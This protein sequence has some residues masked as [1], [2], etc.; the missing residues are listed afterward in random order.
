MTHRKAGAI[1]LA[2]L[3]SFPPMS[4]PTIK[5]GFISRSASRADA[6]RTESGGMAAKE[7]PYS[8]VLGDIDARMCL[9]HSRVSV[10]G[11]M[12]PMKLIPTGGRFTKALAAI[13][14]ATIALMAILLL[15]QMRVHE[16][17][18]AQEETVSLSRIIS[19]QTSRS[20]QA[21][22]LAL[23]T[24]VDR[25]AQAERLGVNFDELPI[26]TMLRSRVEG[27]PQLRSLF[28]TDSDGK[29]LSSA[30]S[31][32][33]PN[34]T[35][36][37]R[38][39]FLAPKS[40]RNGERY[41]GT[42]AINRVDGKR[43]LFFSRDFRSVKGEF[44]GVVVASL[45]IEYLESLYDSIKLD[46]VGPIVLYLEDGTV[47]A[48]APRDHMFAMDS[49]AGP[50][51]NKG[52]KVAPEIKTVRT[53]GENSGVITYRKVAGFPLVLGVD[54]WR[55]TAWVIAVAAVVN[56]MLLLA[57][58][59]LLLRRQGRE[60][61]L[62][63]AALESGERLRA[64]VNSAM[65]AIITVDSDRRV[66]V[67]NPAAERMFGYQEEDVRGMLI[68]YLLSEHS[69][70]AYWDDVAEY[71]DAGVVGHLG[72]SRREIVGLRA[73][74]SE[75]PIESAIAQV[76]VNGSPMFTAILRDIDERR[77]AEGELR[78]SHQQLRELASSLQAVREEERT[79]IARELHDELGQQLLR[80]R[81]DLSWL[82]GRMKDMAPQLLA[83]VAE[84]K[85]FTEGT[86]DA[87]RRVTTQLRPPLLDDLGLADAAR[88]QLN[89][90]AQRTGLDV[91][92][93]IAIDD[94][95]LDQR[96]AI[97]VFRILQES[98][99]NV[100]RHS[101][102]TSVRV[103]LSLTPDGL[104][105]EVVDNGHGREGGAESNLGHG[106][107]GIRERTLM[108]GG[109]TE[110]YSTPSNGFTV[111]VRVPLVVPDSVGVQ[112]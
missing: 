8:S 42:P 12:R 33:A 106:L 72:D 32:P 4:F 74:G 16:L 98:L 109:R 53:V 14:V 30:L 59:A 54:D 69:R 29:I 77:K 52:G 66:V 20:L 37:D 49:P 47:V 111:R 40:R 5:A 92:S 107:I 13:A 103:S 24:T 57:A 7:Y 67:F 112:K 19:E 78:N 73:D 22:D 95:E 84:M 94:L 80:M 105:L 99:T 35:V 34:I 21:V 9:G 75:F 91:I 3:M 96:I 83:K 51:M 36:K 1:R 23:E 11:T 58:T 85:R 82:A 93:T 2:D 64:V 90:F 48:R 15:W 41:V 76:V 86:V 44:A 45:D 17:Q 27:M 25:L 89:E 100:A 110:I 102:A 104:V 50:A 43:T 88:W 38:D 10:A 62:A 81:M 87:L 79:T 63:S 65:D 55:N 28:I 39:Y 97:N 26:H 18:H 46:R 60:E 70:G 101:G 108:L 71:P 56:I 31:H 61:L 68:D 6:A